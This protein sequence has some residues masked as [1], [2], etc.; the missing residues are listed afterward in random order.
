MIVKYDRLKGVPRGNYVLYKI[1]DYGGGFGSY[2][3]DKILF[4][5]KNKEDLEEY[6]SINSLDLSGTWNEYFIKEYPI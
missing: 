3:E 6:C 2:Y 4:Y 5:S 1:I